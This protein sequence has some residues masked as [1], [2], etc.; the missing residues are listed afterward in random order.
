[1]Q[2]A[3]DQNLKK[4]TNITSENLIDNALR[5]ANEKLYDGNQNSEVVCEI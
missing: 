5:K 1:M 4:T 3:I 2:L